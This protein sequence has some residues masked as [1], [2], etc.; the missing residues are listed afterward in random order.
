MQEEVTVGVELAGDIATEFK[1]KQV[2][3]IHSQEILVDS[4]LTQKAQKGMMKQLQSLGVKVCLGK[5]WQNFTLLANK[6]IP[7][8]LCV[9][10][11]KGLCER[12]WKFL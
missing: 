6:L 12:N 3:L 9:N 8:L 10:E 5:H 2:T 11:K 1:G 7:S 4:A